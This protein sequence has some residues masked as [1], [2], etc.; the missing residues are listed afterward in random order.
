M[1][2]DPY[3]AVTAYYM[4]KM[5][6]RKRQVLCKLN[7]NAVKVQAGAMQWTAG[8][9]AMN[10][11]VKGAK[12]FF[13]KALKG[14]A[15]NESAVKPIYSGNGYLMLEPTYR[16]IILE[17]LSKLLCMENRKKIRNEWFLLRIF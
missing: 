5:N 11:G 8:N 15:T 3:S 13:G 6:F 17:D 1:S 4:S 10:S 7:G 14:M 9:V 16:Y 12:D 2:I